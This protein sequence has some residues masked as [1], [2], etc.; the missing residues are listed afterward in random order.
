MGVPGLLLSSLRKHRLV[1]SIWLLLA[2]VVVVLETLQ[3]EAVLVVTVAT[4]PVKTLVV[5]LVPNQ[6]CF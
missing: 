4:Y 6:G 5:G 1:L 2:V 3:A